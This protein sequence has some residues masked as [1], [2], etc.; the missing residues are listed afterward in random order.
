MFMDN[1]HE[2]LSIISDKQPSHKMKYGPVNKDI[3]GQKL[4]KFSCVSDQL[5]NCDNMNQFPYMDNLIPRSL[6]IC[7]H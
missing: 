4:I 5:E 7:M 1:E 2:N 3:L 6:L